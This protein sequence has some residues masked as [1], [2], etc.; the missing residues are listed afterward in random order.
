MTVLFSFHVFNFSLL[1][2]SS[3]FFSVHFLY[4]LPTW[5]PFFVLSFI[6]S[7]AFFFFTFLWFRVF[8]FFFN[9][10]NCILVSIFHIIILPVSYISSPSVWSVFLS[11]LPSPP[12]PPPSHCSSPSLLCHPLISPTLSPSPSKSPPLPLTDSPFFVLFS[13]S[14]PAPRF[15]PSPGLPPLLLLL[16]VLSLLALTVPPLLLFP[17]PFWLTIPASPCHPSFPTHRSPL[18]FSLPAIPPPSL[19]LHHMTTVLL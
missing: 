5:H 19:S 3:V 4:S 14:S 2:L 9:F 8:F 12:S 1:L 11:L 17:V 6:T 15:C 10:G 13:S 16:C 7:Q 18:L